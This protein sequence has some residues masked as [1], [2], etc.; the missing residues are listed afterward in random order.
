M[1]FLE[2]MEKYLSDSEIA[3]ERIGEGNIVSAIIDKDADYR[4]FFFSPEQRTALSS[5]EFPFPISVTASQ[6]MLEAVNALNAGSNLGKFCLSPS[7]QTIRFSCAIYFD[8]A[9][10]EETAEYQFEYTC[11]VLQ[12][13]GD[14]LLE[15]SVGKLDLDGFLREVQRA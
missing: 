5:A 8:E 2:T 15:L 3:H 7:T 6:T 4:F 9:D 12:T 1:A 13:L 11:S 10:A 14:L